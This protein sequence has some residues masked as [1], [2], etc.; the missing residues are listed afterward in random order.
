[1]DTAAAS[2]HRVT[3]PYLGRSTADALYRTLSGEAA[4]TAFRW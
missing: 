1:V 2:A 3:I 4:R